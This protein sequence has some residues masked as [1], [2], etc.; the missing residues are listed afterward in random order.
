M[1]EELLHL[2]FHPSIRGC[3]NAFQPQNGFPSSRHDI[4]LKNPQQYKQSINTG[5]R[6][7]CIVCVCVYM[8]STCMRVHVYK[9]THYIYMYIYILIYVSFFF[10]LPQWC[11]SQTQRGNRI[12]RAD[13]GS[14]FCVQSPIEPG[15][16]KK[17]Q[18]NKK[19]NKTNKEIPNVK[20]QKKE[21][22]LLCLGNEGS[23][24]TASICRYHLWIHV[25]LYYINV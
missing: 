19:Q 9:C 22:F 14:K 1:A 7:V 16:I 10:P 11:L 20:G 6:P 2:F 15:F 4:V 5:K 8:Y 23:H 18:S 12:G 17:Q 3:T 24:Y 13:D 25:V 21:E